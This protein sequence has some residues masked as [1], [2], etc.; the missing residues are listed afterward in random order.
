MIKKIHYCWFGGKPLS[1]LTK[2]CITS[3]K[4]YLPNFE[5]I[6]W[7]EK[8]FD[9]NCSLFVKQAYEQKKWAFVSDYVRFKVLKDEGGLYLDTDMEITQ[10]ISKM[11]ENELFF[12]VEDSKL[13]NGAIIWS[14]NSSNKHISNLLRIY[15]QTEKFNATGDI[16]EQSIPR[17]ITKYFNDLGFNK[18]KDEIQNIDNV[19][20][21]PREYF[22][23]ISY[24]YKNNIFTEK[25]H[26]IHHFS[27]TWTST[28][29]KIKR[30]S[31]IHNFKF[32][33][34]LLDFFSS[35]KRT[36]T[37]KDL[38]ILFIPIII[39]VL[40]LF[41]FWP[42]IDTYDGNYQWNQVQ[43]NYIT[44]AHPFFSTYFV[45]LLSKIWNSKTIVMIFQILSFSLIWMFI[46]K[47]FRN[48]GGKIKSQILYT[49]IISLMP[50]IFVYAITFWKDVLFSYAVLLLTLMFYIGIKNDF[51]YRTL[52][53]VVFAFLI[54]FIKAYR[55]NGIIVSIIT[56]IF[57]A[58]LFVKKKIKKKAIITFFATL[59]IFTAM[60]EI[61]KAIYVNP[62]EDILDAK[63]GLMLYITGSYLDSGVEFT[64]EEIEYLNTLI[65]VDK[66]KELYDPY[67]QNSITQT[68]LLNRENLQ[69][70]FDQFKTLFIKKSISN[71][72]AL[73][74]HI[75]RADALI[76]SPF[77]FGYTY[78]FD[79]TDWGP[80]FYGFNDKVN[81]KF[82]IGKE[83]F[84]GIINLTMKNKYLRNI[85]YRPATALYVSIAIII[86]LVKKTNN[87]KYYYT[88]IPV[89]ANTLSYLPVNLAQD[90]RYVYINYLYLIF[91]ILMSY[92]ELSKLKK[93]KKIEEQ[94]CNNKSTSKK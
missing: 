45:G 59:V 78:I 24:D 18:E 75:I 51:K 2:K 5:I 28:G 82:E 81:T 36:F 52:N 40:A 32:I 86:Y 42:G 90:L 74:K 92:T 94:V 43:S 91:V 38:V 39:F 48:Q 85:L 27:A 4:K 6:E 69:N 13:I 3:W 65:P 56:L 37:L 12:G 17:I 57:L 62:S 61:P 71:P 46:C 33:I 47:T 41:S 30:W 34:Y 66:W 15:D 63:Q 49:I 9:I 55:H 89:L 53:L 1:E 73:A 79:F 72:F 77:P 68:T 58:I 76:W 11:L 83:F 8:N 19:I 88:L 44:D 87:K 25:T 20:I 80:E 7:N 10:D 50:I 31:K 54:V 21:Y 16:F 84:D 35:I 14:K 60:V 64:Q 70:T 23:P 26:G 93:V 67:L 29:E 22:Y